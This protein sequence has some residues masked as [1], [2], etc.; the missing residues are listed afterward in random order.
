[1]PKKTVSKKTE[2]PKEQEIIERALFSAENGQVDAL[3][4]AFEMCGILQDKNKLQIENNDG[5]ITEILDEENHKLAQRLMRDVRAVAAKYMRG[6]IREAEE[7]Y[8]ACLKFAA[9]YYFDEAIRYAEFNRPF[10]KKFYEPRRKQLKPVVDAMQQL[11][12]DELDLLCISEPPGVGKTT[13]ALFYLVWTELKHPEL[14]VLGG[15][16][17]MEFLRGCYDEILRLLDP[18]GEYLWHDIFPNV[19]IVGTNAKDLRIDIGKPKRFQ[20]FQFSSIK[21]GNAGKVRATNLVYCDDLVDGIETA[22]NKER[23]DKLFEQYRTDFRQR[24]QGVCKELHI[25]TRWSVY[26]PIGRLEAQ[27]GDNPRA[28]FI[29]FSAIDADGNSNFDYP[30]NLGFTSQFYKEQMEIMDDASWKA[31]YMNEPIEREGQLYHPFELRRYFTLPDN[32][33]DAIVAVCDIADGGGDYWVCP[34]AFR[35]GNDY[36]I[37]DFI[38]DNGKPDIVEERIVDMLVKYK[39]QAARVET[40]RGGGRVAESIQKKVKSR[41]GLT[42]ITTKWNQTQKDTR[43]IMASGMVKQNFLFK[44]ESVYSREYRSAMNMLTGYTMSGKNKHDDVPDAMSMLTD[45]IQGYE[46]NII[47]VHKRPF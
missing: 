24:K 41:G 14:T 27:Y 26:D 12:D 35:Y 42:K 11:E 29:R 16:H 9:P 25:A 28:K 8:K 7:I 2:K 33:P 36:Y 46:L 31:L 37:E 43:I 19:H 38:C 17:N 13:L 45:M 3:K 30:Y 18:S 15:S 22:L 21:S 20:S 47:T 34:I 5:S 39:V 10:D 6:G 1:M 40:N 32:E 23:L 44:D 4:D